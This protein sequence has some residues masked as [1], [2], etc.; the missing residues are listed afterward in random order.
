M[1]KIYECRVCLGGLKEKNRKLL[2]PK[3]VKWVGDSIVVEFS[4]EQCFVSENLASVASKLVFCAEQR[5]CER[6]SVRSGEVFDDSSLD[7]KAILLRKYQVLIDRFIDSV[8]VDRARDLFLEVGLL[9]AP[10]QEVSE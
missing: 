5:P 8:G 1:E 10:D 4:P 2:W 7:S 9:S 6:I 3:S